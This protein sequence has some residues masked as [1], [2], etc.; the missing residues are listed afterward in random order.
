MKR[1]PPLTLFS[2]SDGMLHFSSPPRTGAVSGP[3]LQRKEREG[4][5]PHW[6]SCMLLDDFCLGAIAL[7]AK[8][9]SCVFATQMFLPSSQSDP[10]HAGLGPF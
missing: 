7:L 4:L 8:R 3:L 6:S 1:I 9:K 5:S 2:A 10:P